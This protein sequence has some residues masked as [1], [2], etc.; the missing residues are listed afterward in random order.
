MNIEIAN[1]LYELRKKNGLS[2][3][4]LASKLGLSR[5]AVSK[6]ERAEA[7]PDTDN[8]VELAKLYNVSL[9][10]LLN[11]PSSQ[12]FVEENKTDEEKVNEEKDINLHIN[13]GGTNVDYKGKIDI[14]DGEDHVLITSDGLH[15]ISE[16]GEEVHIGISGIKIT[17]KDGNKIVKEK[18]S[19]G[20][21]LIE[22]IIMPITTFGSLIAY[23]LLGFLLPNAEGWGCYWVLF[24]LIP[25]I[26]TLLSAIRKR[27]FSEFAYPILVT[28]VYC[29]LGMYGVYHSVTYNLFGQIYNTFWHPFWILFLTIPVYYCLFGPIDKLIHKNDI[30]IE[31]EED[32]DDDDDEGDCD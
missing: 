25:I 14:K 8:L 29:F 19:S 10:E 24:L 6:W 27:K 28:G 26:A 9:D 7:S 1:R 17:D 23:L 13:A 32:D 30:V 22:E 11:I 15:V 3:E 20:W 5:Q 31:K 16:D 12:K 18:K 21:K 4:E 2:Q